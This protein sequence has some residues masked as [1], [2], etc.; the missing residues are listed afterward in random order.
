MSDQQTT[1]AP[2]GAV[3]DAQLAGRGPLDKV[4][5]PA[6][7]DMPRTQGAVTVTPV[8]ASQ[9]IK[10][11]RMRWVLGISLVLVIVAMA[12]AYMVA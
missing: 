5:G 12:V 9:G 10:L 1:Q 8:E 11:G 6:P 3:S 7:A 2:P 4:A